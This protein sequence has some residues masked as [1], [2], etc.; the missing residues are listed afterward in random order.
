MVLSGRFITPVVAAAVVAILIG[1]CIQLPTASSA[2]GTIEVSRV[3]IY[4]SLDEIYASLDELTEEADAAVVAAVTSSREVRI[5]EV[6]FTLSRASVIEDLGGAALQASVEILQVG[7]SGAACHDCARILA[8][9]HTYLLILARHRMSSGDET[10]HWVAIGDQGIFE[11][12]GST[13][14]YAGASLWDLAPRYPREI[15]PE[16]LTSVARLLGTG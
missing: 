6:P 7:G 2:R 16:E 3:R 9:G 15:A 12:T 1:V 11:F 8:P 10:G 4:A 13:Y 14:R 5:G